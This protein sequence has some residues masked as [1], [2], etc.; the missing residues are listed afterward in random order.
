MPLPSG[1]LTSQIPHW[2]PVFHLQWLGHI[3]HGRQ[4][5]STTIVWNSPL[6]ELI[7]SVMVSSLL[8]PAFGTLSLLLYFRLPSTSLSSK[9]RSI[10][11]LGTRWHDFFVILFR[12]F[13]K[14]FYSFHYISF[15]FLK[16]CRL[17]KGHI[18]PVLC[19][20]SL[21]KKKKKLR[22]ISASP[23]IFLMFLWMYFLI[24]CGVDLYWNVF[25]DFFFFFFFHSTGVLLWSFFL[26]AFIQLCNINA[27][28]PIF[29]ISTSCSRR[30]ST[31]YFTRVS[32]TELGIYFVI[33]LLSFSKRYW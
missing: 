5:L 12:Y 16:G 18:V 27:S 7:G 30:C 28:S 2:L 26:N 20:H 3:P 29:H 25:Y 13:I 6:R 11:T 33:F 19:S 17:E 21:K 10:T 9:G 15:P 32:R 14:L 4:H 23:L 22:D 1:G 31:V 8:L 24:E